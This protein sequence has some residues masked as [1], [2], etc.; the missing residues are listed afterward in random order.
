MRDIR[1]R[2]CVPP[3]WRREALAALAGARIVVSEDAAVGL[4][5]TPHRV[6]DEQVDRWT[7]DS[8]PHLLVGVWPH[9]MEVGP[10]ALPGRGP[11]AHCVAAEAPD[12]EH[13]D[14]TS[15]TA[16]PLGLLAVAA[17]WAARD[18]AAWLAGRTPST[19]ASGWWVGDDPG[20]RPRRIERHPY[21]G[22]AWWE[23]ASEPDD[24]EPAQARLRHAERRT[25]A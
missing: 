17:G 23:Q 2:L 7:V 12:T 13:V 1:L 20:L 18:A 15:L 22:C 5:L 8:V 19:W 9:G 25:S 3:A 6:V 10:W 24:D 11:C 4:A 14:L 21:C 16:P